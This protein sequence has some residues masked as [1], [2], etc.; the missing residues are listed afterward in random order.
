MYTCVKPISDSAVRLVK[1]KKEVID[2]EKITKSSLG[3]VGE[4]YL[5]AK[6]LRDFNIVSVKV[7]QQFF[8]YDLITNNGKKVEVK[9]A[10]PSW[11]EKK[12]K[13]KIYKWLVWKFRRPPKQQHKG[14][15]DL[16]VCIGF[17][18][19]DMSKEPRVFIIPSAELINEKTCKPREVWMIMIEPKGK[20]KFLDRENRWDLIV[21]D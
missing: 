4:T 19:E 18:S 17:E 6:L 15:S 10:R 8:A 14:S 20:T 13:E 7:P 1:R 2:L 12:R 16:V 5:I 21:K 3:L 9:T 11:N